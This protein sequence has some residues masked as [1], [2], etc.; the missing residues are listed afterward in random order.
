[1]T[2]F[3]FDNLNFRAVN[4]LLLTTRVFVQTALDGEMHALHMH[5]YVFSQSYV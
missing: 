1:M 2:V 5:R 4:T 3:F